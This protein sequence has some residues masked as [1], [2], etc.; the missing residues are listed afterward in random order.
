MNYSWPDA[1][2]DSVEVHLLNALTETKQSQA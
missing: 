1:V 2:S